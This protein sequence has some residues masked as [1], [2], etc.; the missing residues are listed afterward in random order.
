[1]ENKSLLILGTLALA[2]LAVSAKVWHCFY[3]VPEESAKLYDSFIRQSL[4]TGFLTLGGF[5]LSMKTF[6]LVNVKKEVYDSDAYT[7]FLQECRGNNL[8][9]NRYASLYE[10]QRGLTCSIVLSLLSSA[11]QFTLGL[12]GY[13]WAK[14]LA[15]TVAALALAMVL[16]SVWLLYANT[17]AW[18]DYARKAKEEE[19]NS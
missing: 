4:F 6:V 11:S 7:K 16:W 19:D 15:S 3:F 9:L 8:T 10:L 18:I 12:T 5:L 17:R 13:W 2:A 14:A 1:M